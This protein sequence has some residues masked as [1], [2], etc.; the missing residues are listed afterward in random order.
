MG[1]ESKIYIR[2]RLEADRPTKR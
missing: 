1:M 2:P